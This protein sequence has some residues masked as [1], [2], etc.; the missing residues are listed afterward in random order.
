MPVELGHAS[1]AIVLGVGIAIGAGAG[2]ALSMRRRRV[3]GAEAP[4]APPRNADGS[5]PVTGLQGLSAFERIIDETDDGPGASAPQVCVLHAGI[6][7]FRLVNDMGGREHG[8]KVLAA[9][10]RALSELGA[11]GSRVYRTGGDEFVVWMRAPL[12]VAESLAR[13]IVERCALDLQVDGTRCPVGI[14]VGVAASPQHGVPRRIPVMAAA[15]MRHV[16]RSGGGAY[17]VFDPRIEAEHREELAIARDLRDAIDRNA[18]ELFYQP[19]IDASSLQITAVEALLRWKHPTLGM[20]SPARFVP[21]AEK[22]GLIGALGNW[23]LD[24]ALAQA[25]IWRK[26]GMRM[27]VAINV[28]GYQMRQDDFAVRLER[29]L[30]EHG[31]TPGRFTCE[32]TE[33]VA[34][35]DTQVTRRAFERLEKI[36]VHVSIDDFGTGHSS[37]A[38]LRRLPAKELKI[39]RAFVE[40][41]GRSDDALAIVRSIIEMAHTLG[42]RVV[43]EGVETDPQRD[44]LVTSGCDELQGYL[45]ARPMNARAITLWA[46]DAPQSLAQTFRPSIFTETNL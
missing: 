32:I 20:M 22:H 41:L 46:V 8:D 25:A 40:D 27:R 14:S 15:A 11:P 33:S 16:K 23:V 34:M 28:S 45:F 9:T 30:K 4:A 43:A 26:A 38:A 44:L 19:K 21:I 42:M 6:D 3:G 5:D 10:A 35:E 24:T 1:L 7:G 36:G 39:D 29:G 2:A 31:L 37:L 12:D 13:R 18:L 17:A